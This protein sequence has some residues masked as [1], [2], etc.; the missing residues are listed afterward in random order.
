MSINISDIFSKTT[1]A[2]RGVE[3]YFNNNLSCS[4]VEAAG[5]AKK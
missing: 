3:L 2:L 1:C 5:E 4:D